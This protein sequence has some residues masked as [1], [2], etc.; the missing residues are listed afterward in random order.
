[1]ECQALEP[2]LYDRLTGRLSE[3]ESQVVDAHLAQ[4]AGCRATF[5]ELARTVAVLD[6]WTVPEP[7]PDFQ[8][9]LQ[10]QVAAHLHTS[11]TR[12][13]PSTEPVAAPPIP[14]TRPQ[15]NGLASLLRRHWFPVMGLALAATLAGIV[16]VYQGV[17]PG[18][19]PPAQ[20]TRGLQL[21]FAE[22]PIIIETPDLDRAR[23][24]LIAILHAQG[25]TLLRTQPVGDDLELTITIA[26][27]DEPQLLQQLTRLG[28]VSPPNV[29]YKDREGHL[30]VRLTK[31]GTF[32]R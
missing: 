31:S 26:P 10:A 7:S 25:G 29:G 8:A 18:D 16:V 17:G 13:A 1:M 9:R 5:E 2:L 19:H 3:T 6:T 24:D 27:Q 28:K 15:R 12:S 32:P 11:P 14:A 23:A 21:E 4:C 30:L 20:M 22:T